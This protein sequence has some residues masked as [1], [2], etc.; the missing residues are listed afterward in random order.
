MYHKFYHVYAV[1]TMLC[2][3]CSGARCIAFVKQYIFKIFHVEIF[4]TE[5][6]TK[7]EF[8]ILN[9]AS[10]FFLLHYYLV[11]RYFADS[12]FQ[13]YYRSSY[14]QIL[15]CMGCTVENWFL[16]LH[17]LNHIS[18]V[19][20]VLSLT[21]IKQYHQARA[22]SKSHSNLNVPCKKQCTHFLKVN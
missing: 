15:C 12:V 7:N 3:Y 8:Y 19:I 20:E 21:C 16:L 22:K 2:K 11:T 1:Y 4:H 17:W 10:I 13:I 14:Q 6:N 18:T 9:L 5:I